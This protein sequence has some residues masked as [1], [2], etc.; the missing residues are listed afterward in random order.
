M[1]NLQSHL[2][3]EVPHA[4]THGQEASP[5]NS[6]GRVFLFIQELGRVLRVQH[7]LDR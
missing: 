1:L 3:Q 2:L 5:R 4:K 6:D 7:G